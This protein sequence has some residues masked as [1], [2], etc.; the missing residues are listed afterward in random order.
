MTTAPP[1]YEAATS[2]ANPGVQDTKPT[3]ITPQNGAVPQTKTQPQPPSKHIFPQA[4][5]FYHASISHSD[6]AIALSAESAPLFHISTH[7]SFSSQPSIVLH[8]SAQPTSPPLANA[9][10]HSFSSKTDI[11]ILSSSSGKAVLSASLIKDGAFSSAHTFSI[12]GAGIFEWK[13]S[14]GPEVVNLRGKS[15]GMKLVRKGSRDVVAAWA[16]PNS[17][18]RKKGKIAFLGRGK[19]PRDEFGGVWEMMVVISILSLMEKGRRRNNSSAAGGGGGG[20]C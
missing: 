3:N 4:F 2:S 9:Y 14:S 17:G 18:T 15:H 13:N 1:T 7:G 16:P 19:D 8:S 5:G 6:M 12:P 11:S 20:G 10:F